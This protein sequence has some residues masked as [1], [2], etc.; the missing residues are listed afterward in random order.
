MI[1]I[2]KSDSIF[3]SISWFAH[4][5]IHVYPL[6]NR[7]GFKGNSW[8]S[9]LA[10]QDIH[11]TL[12]SVEAKLLM[13]ILWCLTFKKGLHVLSLTF[14]SYSNPNSEGRLIALIANFRLE[15]IWLTVKNTL[16][17]CSNELITCIESFMM[18][19]PGNLSKEALV[20]AN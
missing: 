18:Q 1:I 11:S 8:F 2:W 14:A 16:A 9:V 10:R 6:L 15:W 4:F 17:Y 13:I 12:G 19:A 5:N 7:T 20:L 3:L